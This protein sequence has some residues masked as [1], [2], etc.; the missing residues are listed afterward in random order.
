VR[1]ADHEGGVRETIVYGENGLFVDGNPNAMA[2][3]IQRLLNDSGFARALG[4]SAVRLVN[5]RWSLNAAHAR[6][7]ELLQ[8]AVSSPVR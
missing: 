6:L 4:E 3:A 5:K 1:P 2:T 8:V 7:E